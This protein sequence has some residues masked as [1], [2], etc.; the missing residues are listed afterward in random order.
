MLRITIDR[1]GIDHGST[2]PIRVHAPDRVYYAV[3]VRIIGDSDLIYEP[4]APLVDGTR[5]WIECERV[6]A[7]LDPEDLHFID[8]P[9][10]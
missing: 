8:I 1:D 2:H 3:A 9:A 5:L 10:A 4:D 7:K 6:R